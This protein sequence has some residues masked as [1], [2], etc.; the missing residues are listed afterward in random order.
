MTIAASARC[1][2]LSYRDRIA[3]TLPRALAESPL[4]VGD[5]GE[6][7]AGNFAFAARPNDQGSS[8]GM[9]G[10]VDLA[11][12]VKY[13]AAAD[14]Q[15][16]LERKAAADE[17]FAWF[18]A[19]DDGLGITE[20]VRVRVFVQCLLHSAQTSFGHVLAAIDRYKDVFKRCLARAAAAASASLSDHASSS[21]SSSADSLSVAA[22]RRIML[23]ECA[24]Y[25]R[26]SP[27]HV[28]FVVDKLL[29]FHF[30]DAPAVVAFAFDAA[31]A[32]LAAS[33]SDHDDDG[34]GSVLCESGLEWELL[35]NALVKSQRR[36]AKIDASLTEA[37]AALASA[38][39][40]SV[41]SA[42]GSAGDSALAE[43]RI[44]EIQAAA[45]ATVRERVSAATAIRA[46]L[47]LLLR[48]ASVNIDAAVTDAAADADDEQQQMGR[49]VR[50]ATR[51]FS[52]CAGRVQALYRAFGRELSE[53]GSQAAASNAVTRGETDGDQEAVAD[54]ARVRSVW[55][56]IVEL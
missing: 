26:R 25:W 47:A 19:E 53:H 49:A 36:A 18:D 24:A 13:S 43:R 23:S 27:Q 39:A 2:R 33:V 8:S 51:A 35:A 20:S 38:S 30:V 21:S 10:D 12:A 48:T 54:S 1:V 44:A 28:S 16:L 37:Q 15:A 40:S 34:D 42:N 31:D 17:V 14:L 7:A 45:H 32:R 56:S 41:A 52:V 5:H 4:M 46:R 29:A 11:Y 9:G 50:R 22:V 6:V 3:K 55:E